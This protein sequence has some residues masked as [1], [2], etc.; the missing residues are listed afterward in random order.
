MPFCWPRRGERTREGA[1]GVVVVEG[2]GRVEWEQRSAL[3]GLRDGRRRWTAPSVSEP[4][5]LDLGLVVG[6]LDV[7][8]R[9]LE[10]SR[11]QQAPALLLAGLS[12]SGQGSSTGQ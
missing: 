2:L 11:T 5:V 7:E 12:C 9:T 4:D 3:A 6:L 10:R 1:C 8:L